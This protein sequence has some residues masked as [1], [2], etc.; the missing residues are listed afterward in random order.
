MGST[1]SGEY[2]GDQRPQL[3]NYG[4]DGRLNLRSVKLYADG[5]CLFNFF[6]KP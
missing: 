6:Q 1:A 4:K 3:I 2:W 5:P